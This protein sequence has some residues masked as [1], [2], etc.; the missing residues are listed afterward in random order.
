MVVPIYI[1]EISPKH[2][3]GRFGGL[4]QFFIVTGIAASYW[5][6]YAV[7]RSVSDHD[8]SLWRVPLGLQLLPAVLLAA[9]IMAMVESPRWLCAVG[10]DRLAQ[11]TIATLRGLEENDIH[12][13]AEV[14]GM[15]GVLREE[16]RH[17]QATYNEILADPANRLRLLIGCALQA[18]QQLS[19]TN[20]INYYSPIIFKSIGLSSDEADLLATGVYGLVKMAATLGGTFWLADSMGRRKM[21]ELGGGSMAFCMWVVF[22]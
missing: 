8:D 15:K 19:G 17:Y 6:N 13:V 7:K 1:A 10:R 11:A 9:G 5:I 3:R 4:W 21:L 12:I 14:N 20:I 2:L 22:S 18:L 16:N